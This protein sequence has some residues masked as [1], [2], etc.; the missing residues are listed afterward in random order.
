VV[1][2][3]PTEGLDE[4]SAEFVLGRIRDRY[5][6]GVVLIISHRIPNGLC[7]TRRLELNEGSVT[8]ED[9]ESLAN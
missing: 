3:E 9:F 2:D 6:L 5:H 8:E 1:F 7:A 4:D